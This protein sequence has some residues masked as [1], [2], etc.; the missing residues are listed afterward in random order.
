MAATARIKDAKTVTVTAN[1]VHTALNK[2]DKFLLAIVLVDGDPVHGDQVEGPF[3]IRQPF[4]KEPEPFATSI[5]Y[6]LDK[7][8]AVANSAMDV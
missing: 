8:L 3:Y 6:D 7:P 5:Q 1:E 4:T 2:G